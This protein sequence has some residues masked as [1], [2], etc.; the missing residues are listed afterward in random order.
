M[1][2]KYLAI[3]IIAFV[4]LVI[5]VFVGIKVFS[6]KDNVTNNDKTQLKEPNTKPANNTEELLT[7]SNELTNTNVTKDKITFDSG[8]NLASGDKIAIWL[9]STPKFLGWF[10][11][12]EENGTKYINGL[13]QALAKE[14]ID[15][16]SHHLAIA[17]KDNETLGYVNVEINEDN[18]IEE[19]DAIKELGISQD[20]YSY[21]LFYPQVHIHFNKDYTFYIDNDGVSTCPTTDDGKCNEKY[22]LVADKV[23]FESG[24][25]ELVEKDSSH[26]MLK[27]TFNYKGGNT[28]DVLVAMYEE[29]NGG[30]T[31]TFTRMEMAVSSFTKG[32]IWLSD[33]IKEDSKVMSLQ[34]TF[35][36]V[37]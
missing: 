16:G 32:S 8:I 23:D 12:Q 4:V 15:S 35:K 2:K 26:I 1:N 6:S 17:N 5:G 27:L 24:K 30:Y 19:V 28:E 9:Y 29:N 37:E 3:G 7:S 10:E 36:Y 13:E 20:F 18:N 11:V 31:E 33:N 22:Y 25:Y 21:I 34:P 14:N